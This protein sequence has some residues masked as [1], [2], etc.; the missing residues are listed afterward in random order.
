MKPNPKT[1]KI[2]RGKIFR[3]GLSI[4]FPFTLMLLIKIPDRKKIGIISKTWGKSRSLQTKQFRGLRHEVI[5]RW[6]DASAGN[7]VSQIGIET[8][9]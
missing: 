9:V 7:P 6:N 5:Q 8:D 2:I 3:L 4:G 1:I